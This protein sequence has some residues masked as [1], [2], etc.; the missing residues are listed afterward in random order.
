MS[1][2]ISQPLRSDKEKSAPPK[3]GDS[4]HFQ[5]YRHNRIPGTAREYSSVTMDEANE[6]EIQDMD[7]EISAGQKMLSAVS[8]SL[9]TSLLGM[10]LFSRPTKI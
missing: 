8:G 6:P 10:Q 1:G 5:G 3:D 2:F 7:T 9:L 4:E